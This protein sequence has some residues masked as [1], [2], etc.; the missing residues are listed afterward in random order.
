[1]ESSGVAPTLLTF[2]SLINACSKAKSLPRAEGWLAAM[3][4]RGVSPDAVSY[5][6]VIHACATEQNA[7]RAERWLE[8]V[9]ADAGL[10]AKRDSPLL[11]C[12]NATIQACARAGDHA[13]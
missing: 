9:H 2:N 6:T 10:L 3:R 4:S 5:S 11:F 7:K 13:R 1:M 12:Y 8:K